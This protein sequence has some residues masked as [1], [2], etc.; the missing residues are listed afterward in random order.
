VQIREIPNG[1]GED[2]GLRRLLRDR[3]W[4]HMSEDLSIEHFEEIAATTIASLPV[5]IR[6][7]CEGVVVTVADFATTD[8]LASVGLID[9]WTLSGLYEG[10][11]L[12]ERSIWNESDMPAR[13]WLF[14]MPILAEMRSRCIDLAELV[15]HVLIHEFGH[16]FGFS[17]SEM[18][19]IEK[20]PHM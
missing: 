7:Q 15:H 4:H 13:V 11:P 10:R 19:A 12:P 17:D 2:E 1:V 9:R 20:A 8:Q 16:H 6:A 14:R 3:T 5:A 18:H